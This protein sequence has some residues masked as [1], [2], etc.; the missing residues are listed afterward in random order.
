MKSGKIRDGTLNPKVG[1]SNPPP[2]TKKHQ[3]GSVQ[4]P[5]FFVILG[6]ID[7]KSQ[8][9]PRSFRPY[10][11]DHSFAAYVAPWYLIAIQPSEVLPH[12]LPPS[13][14][15]CVTVTVAPFG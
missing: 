3:V 15:V 5:T 6:Q 4:L 12:R 13:V 14:A 9:R 10:D 1:G 8:K 2:A 7:R 11:P